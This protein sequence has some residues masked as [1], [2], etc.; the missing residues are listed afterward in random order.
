MNLLPAGLAITLPVAATTASSVVKRVGLSFQRLLSS[1]AT[2]SASTDSNGANSVGSGALTLSEKLA[3]IAEGFRNWLSQHQINSPFELEF[4]SA[5][6]FAENSKG[7]EGELSVRG[8]QSS[9]IKQL[10]QQNPEQLSQLSKL[11]SEIQAS[12][13]MAGTGTKLQIT[14]LD[15]S[16][17]Y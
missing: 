17:G 3:Q 5:S 12:I 7:S 8:S 16:I 10:L 1:S 13:P 14:D 2:P 11:L 9:E 15:S 4:S 6:S